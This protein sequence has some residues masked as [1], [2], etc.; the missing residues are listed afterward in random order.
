VTTTLTLTP[1]DKRGKQI[2][3]DLEAESFP[4]FRWNLN[5]GARSYAFVLGQEH[6]V[7]ATGPIP[8]TYRAEQEPPCSRTRAAPNAELDRPVRD[9]LVTRGPPVD[10]GGQ[11]GFTPCGGHKIRR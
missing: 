1:S 6:Q 3:D 4:P 11:A 10:A 5:T 9:R 8:A 7:E 2:L